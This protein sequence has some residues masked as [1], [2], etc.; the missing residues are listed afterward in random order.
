MSP[1]TDTPTTGPDN[2]KIPIRRALVSV[3]DKTGLEELARVVKEVFAVL[4]QRRVGQRVECVA[5][6]RVTGCQRRPLLVGG[7]PGRV[8]FGLETGSGAHDR[9]AIAQPQ[10]PD[11]SGPAEERQ[12]DRDR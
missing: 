2:G 8:T 1:Q 10:Q 4:T 5:K 3:Y 11:G 6:L 9:L 12:E 7:L